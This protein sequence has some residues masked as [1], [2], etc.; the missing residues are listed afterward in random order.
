MP[1]G[2]CSRCGV[3]VEVKL[4]EPFTEGGMVSPLCSSCTA[5]IIL[6]E[7]GAIV[8]LR[9]EFEGA[10]FPLGKITM[11][12]GAVGALA[13]ACQHA[14]TFLCR[15]VS[16]DW[17]EDGH[18]DEIH[19]TPDEQIRGWEASDDRGKIN[20]WSLLN[21]KDRIMSRYR[22]GRGARLWVI[23]CLDPGGGTVVL[24]PDEY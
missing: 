21:R 24:L 17:G 19:L 18:C 7:S 5:R 22:T 1:K 15:H 14:V 4:T 8:E 23:T 11:T 10:R 6:N 12:G 20:N 16:G 2:S 9:Q 3:L 13:D